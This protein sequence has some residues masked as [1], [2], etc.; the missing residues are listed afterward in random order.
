MKVLF[1]I[2]LMTVTSCHFFKNE[3]K[4]PFK[5]DEVQ[6]VLIS[7]MG[8][9]EV[10]DLDGRLFKNEGKGYHLSPEKVQPW[11]EN[12]SRI[13]TLKIENP[14][15]PLPQETSASLELTLKN[16]SRYLILGSRSQNLHLAIVRKIPADEHSLV[17]TFYLS[18]EAYESIFKS[19]DSLR[20]SSLP[21]KNIQSIRYEWKGKTYQLD[22]SQVLN[23][24]TI[25]ETISFDKYAFSGLVT[26]EVKDM[27]N[28]EKRINGNVPGKVIINTDKGPFA[29][30]FAKPEAHK[31]QTLIYVE[32]RNEIY[33]A[34]IQNWYQLEMLFGKLSRE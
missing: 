27:F 16:K 9:S 3:Q 20:E 21:L 32:G 22:S 11:L 26:D 25:L 4:V 5:T 23:V 17:G 18:R 14:G 10:F 31:P 2:L 7:S 34:E 15:L 1:S 28:L 8:H 19:S 13:E 24:K 6:R 29:L 12:L 30:S 33:S